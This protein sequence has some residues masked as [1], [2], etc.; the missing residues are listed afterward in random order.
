VPQP[1]GSEVL[2]FLGCSG[3][4]DG[5]KLLRNVCN[6]DESTLCHSPWNLTLYYI[7]CN[8]SLIFHFYVHSYTFPTPKIRL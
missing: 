3:S 2:P 1:A 6:T 4:C 5:R 7:S 8:D